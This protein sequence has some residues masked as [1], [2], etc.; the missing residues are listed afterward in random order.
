MKN[1]SKIMHINIVLLGYCND[2]IFQAYFHIQWRNMILKAV[3]YK[4]LCILSLSK[5]FIPVFSFLGGSEAYQP[6]KTSH[7]G[8]G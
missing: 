6:G 4:K 8:S 1:T 7:S 2:F 3:G 5:N